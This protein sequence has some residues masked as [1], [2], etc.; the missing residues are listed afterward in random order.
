MSGADLLL[1]LRRE[2]ERSRKERIYTVTNEGVTTTGG[3]WDFTLPTFYKAAPLLLDKGWKAD[4]TF[5]RGYVCCSDLL[6]IIVWLEHRGMEQLRDTEYKI[7]NHRVNPGNDGNEIYH[8]REWM[9]DLG[10]FTETRTDI[11]GGSPELMD[12]KALVVAIIMALLGLKAAETNSI[13]WEGPGQFILAGGKVADILLKRESSTDFDIFAVGIEPEKAEEFM[14]K[15]ASLARRYTE[16]KVLLCE[17]PN[18]LTLIVDTAEIQLIRRRYSSVGEVLHSF[19]LAPSAVAWDGKQFWY[20]PESSYAYRSGVFLL[21]PE[22]KRRPTLET[23]ISKYVNFKGFAL[24]LADLDTSKFDSELGELCTENTPSAIVDHGGDTQASSR[25]S[26][27]PIKDCNSY[28]NDEGEE[29]NIPSNIHLPYLSFVGVTRRPGGNRYLVEHISPNSPYC[30][31]SGNDDWDGTHLKSNVKKLCDYG[32][33]DYH[34]TPYLADHNLYQLCAGKS[35]FVRVYN[36]KAKGGNCEKWSIPLP[37]TTRDE[38]EKMIRDTLPQLT[39]KLN[40]GS[41]YKMDK[42][43]KLLDSFFGFSKIRNSQQLAL[44]GLILSSEKEEPP[45]GLINTITDIMFARIES[46][47][48]KCYSWKRAPEDTDL[49]SQE[50]KEA[51]FPMA[52]VARKEW[53]GGYYANL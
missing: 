33:V 36:E 31:A 12:I 18:C 32:S 6:E 49:S 28:D 21:P 38:Y 34:S 48:K 23:R 7:Y 46:A 40:Y 19:D 29:D 14:L 52:Y 43:I 50:Q 37:L 20:T 10:K 39:S 53:Y 27:E 22:D 3:A 44:M 15:L 8:T 25:F 51:L 24:V 42:F 4:G 41:S 45:D 26:T 17:T 1:A 9:G 5:I 30:S 13:K 11:Y 35:Y 2:S 16:A 47:K